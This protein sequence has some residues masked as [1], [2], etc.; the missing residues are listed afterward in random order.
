MS[1]LAW[2]GW[3]ES[4]QLLLSVDVEAD[5]VDLVWAQDTEN[6]QPARPENPVF[7]LEH[8]FT[9]NYANI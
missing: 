3:C 6:P 8:A 5:L 7:P 9:G 4:V 2:V 1:L